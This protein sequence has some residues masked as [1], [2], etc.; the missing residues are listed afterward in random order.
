MKVT[1]IP[2]TLNR[3]HI[4]EI[5]PEICEPAPTLTNQAQPKNTVDD[6]LA[7]YCQMFPDDQKCQKPKMASL[8]AMKEICET[9]PHTQEFVSC[10]FDQYCHTF[11]INYSISE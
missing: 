2:E 10:F 11:N 7:E 6:E 4:C 9:E 5:L 8:D 3:E 1:D